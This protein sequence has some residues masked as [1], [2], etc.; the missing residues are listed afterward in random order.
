[1]LYFV[2]LAR[3]SCRLSHGFYSY[4]RS[5]LNTRI[6]ITSIGCRVDVNGFISRQKTEMGKC[7]IMVVSLSYESIKFPHLILSVFQ[8]DLMMSQSSY[9]IFN[10]FRVSW[11]VVHESIKLPHFHTR[12]IDSLLMS[13]SS[14]HLLTLLCSIPISFMS[15]SSYLIVLVQ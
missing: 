5:S 12:S 11:L 9:L 1:M 6:Q 4:W 13:H 10:L 7:V 15:Q 2:R 14:S 8:R 3:E